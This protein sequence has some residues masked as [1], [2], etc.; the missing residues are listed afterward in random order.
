MAYSQHTLYGS[1]LVGVI[2][3]ASLAGIV[4]TGGPGEA[5]KEREDLARQQALSETALALACYRYDCEWEFQG[6]RI[7]DLGHEVLAFIRSGEDWQVAWRSVIPARREGEL[8]TSGQAEDSDATGSDSADIR[9]RCYSLMES[10]EV[11]VAP[12]LDDSLLQHMGISVLLPV[13]GLEIIHAGQ[14]DRLGPPGKLFG[15]SL[16]DFLQEPLQ[17][18]LVPDLIGDTALAVIDGGGPGGFAR[19]RGM[20]LDMFFNDIVFQ[21][22]INTL[23]DVGQGNLVKRFQIRFIEGN[24]LLAESKDIIFSLPV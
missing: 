17:I 4:I 9:R 22:F 7:R 15:N 10:A 20:D 8:I 6:K 11:W 14:H 12:V 19:R 13:D 2:I 5:R 1:V 23:R 24:G 16:G 18:L 3:A 21:D